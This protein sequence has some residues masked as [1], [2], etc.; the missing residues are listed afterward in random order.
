MTNEQPNADSMGGWEPLLTAFTQPEMAPFLDLDLEAFLP[1]AL[2]Q[3][4]RDAVKG[5]SALPDYALFAVLRVAP[6]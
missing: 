5:K 3:W 6:R 4:S 1:P 2:A